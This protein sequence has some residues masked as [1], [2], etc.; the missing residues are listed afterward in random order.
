M[1]SMG[2]ESKKRIRTFLMVFFVIVGS[3]LFSILALYQYRKLST[4]SSSQI[5]FAT[6]NDMYGLH[7]IVLTGYVAPFMKDRSGGMEI[8][9]DSTASLVRDFLPVL[10]PIKKCR[11]EM[12]KIVTNSATFGSDHEL[13][14]RSADL[15][16]SCLP[17]RFD[18]NDFDHPFTSSTLLN[19]RDVLDARN[20][21]LRRRSAVH[22]CR[23]SHWDRTC[24]FW[25]SIHSLALRAE[26]MLALQRKNLMKRMTSL[27][28][29]S[30]L[31]LLLTTMAGGLT[32]CRG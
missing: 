9:R 19:K 30:F 21:I 31:S 32:Q 2:F 11:D 7:D 5:K 17:A 15:M 27:K 14:E 22:A 28:L 26:Q 25:I 12:I 6:P 13:I 4:S 3:V 23:D 1:I 10:H 29:E 20:P 24:S 8:V 16:W 18:Q